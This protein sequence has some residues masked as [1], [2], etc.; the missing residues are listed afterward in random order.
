L[1]GPH[2]GQCVAGGP[3]AGCW[4]FSRGGRCLY[5]ASLHPRPSVRGE[6]PHPMRSDPVCAEHSGSNTVNLEKQSLILRCAVP[7]K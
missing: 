7:M 6:E 3:Q 4:L 1:A 2:L 5:I